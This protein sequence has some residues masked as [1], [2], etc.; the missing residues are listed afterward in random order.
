MSQSL[1]ASAIHNISVQN[2]TCVLV[3]SNSGETFTGVDDNLFQQ[4]FDVLLK[5]DGLRW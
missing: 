3:V 4:G 2:N 1:M 5:N